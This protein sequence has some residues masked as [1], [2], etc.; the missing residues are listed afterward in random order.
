MRA[1]LD[2]RVAVGKCAIKA[3]ED[4]QEAARTIG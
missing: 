2:E 3:G 1:S 4:L